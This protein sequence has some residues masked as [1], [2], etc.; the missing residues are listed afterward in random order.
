M[1]RMALPMLA[2]MLVAAPVID[3]APARAESEMARKA[4]DEYMDLESKGKT[5]SVKALEDVRNK[6]RLRRNVDG[7]VQLKSSRGE[8]WSVRLDMEVPGAI[9]LRDPN[10]SIYAVQTETVQQ[11]DLSDDYICLLM[12]ADGGWEKQMSPIEYAGEDGKTQQLKLD[13]KEFREVIGIL[14]EA[15]DEMEEGDS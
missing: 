9:L 15:G 8:W 6:Y 7:R 2:A 12:F 3:V 10:G 4:V 11:V 5:R 13:E 1:V 14:K